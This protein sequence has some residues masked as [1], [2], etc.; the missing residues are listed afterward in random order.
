[1]NDTDTAAE[2]SLMESTPHEAQQPSVVRVG[3]DLSGYDVV[4][5]HGVHERLLSLLPSD[6]RRA[7]LV[8][9]KPVTDL[10]QRLA[11]VL[12]GVGLE[13]MVDVLPDAEAAKTVDVAAGLWGQ[14]GQAGFT[15]T[16]V[17][18]AVGGG[19]VTDL[20]GFVAATWLR[21]VPLINVPTTLLGMVDAAV[22]GK[23]GVNTAEGKNLV[24]A[25]HSPVGVLCDLGALHSLPRADLAAGLAEVIK[26][27]FIAD[28]VI[29]DLIEADP[30]AALDPA[31]ATLTELIERKIAVKA[32][33]V[34]A[35]PREAGLREI[36]N[37]GHTFGHAIEQVEK[38]SWR[39]GDAVAV[40]MVF[41][42]ELAARAGVL[43]EDDVQRHRHILSLVGLPTAY[44]S[45]RW[46]DLL[47]AMS[48][49]K[50]TRGATLRFVV[51]DGIAQPARLEGP[52]AS[53]LVAAYEAVSAG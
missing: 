27:G 36:L 51:L 4:I 29:L 5:G 8:H 6:A 2:A 44:P 1:M 39:H 33:V 13:V 10:A 11:E 28:P 15:R 23:T 17:V 46:P 25:F 12:R 14:L 9:A 41:V 32:H 3:D 40:G 31:S 45:G 47:A 18:V 34:S 16:D 43:A 37:Y 35:D 24:G 38:Y 20:G 49:D 26:G 30:H 21:G 52:D 19:A 48:R 53:L 7:L 42:A 22:G 50:K